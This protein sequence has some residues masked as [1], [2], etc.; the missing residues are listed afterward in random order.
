MKGIH[1][2]LIEVHG[3]TEKNQVKPSRVTGFSVRVKPGASQKQICRSA[4][5]ATC[6]VS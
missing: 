6:S 2:D 1:Y 5:A 4:T 3:G